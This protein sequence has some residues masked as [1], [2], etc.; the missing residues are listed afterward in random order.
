MCKQAERDHESKKLLILMERLK[1][2]L[3]QQKDPA[4]D[5]LRKPV[6]PVVMPNRRALF[7]R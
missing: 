2:Q 1:H 4:T 5:S 3:A 6:A 7:E